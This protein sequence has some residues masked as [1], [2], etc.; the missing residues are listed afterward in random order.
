[1]SYESGCPMSRRR[2]FGAAGA[3]AAGALIAT[4]GRAKAAA[5][6]PEPALVHTMVRPDR[7]GRLF[8]LKPFAEPSPKV[9]AALKA[10][11]APGGPMDVRDDLAAGPLNLIL[12]PG[13]N[14]DNPTHTAGMTFVGQFIDHDLTLDATSPLAT[15][16][17]P[18]ATINRRSPAFD[19]DSVYGSGPFGDPVLYEADRMRLKVGRRGDYEDVPRLPGRDAR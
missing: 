16:T 9:I 10:L 18:E 1:M 8:D 11:G 6:E 12:N 5:P 19:L 17:R 2:L 7:F 4:P 14:G 3:T 15:P 13:P